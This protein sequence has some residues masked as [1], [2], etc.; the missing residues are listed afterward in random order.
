LVDRKQYFNK[1]SPEFKIIF[2]VNMGEFDRINQD[3][4]KVKVSFEIPILK[5]FLRYYRQA[6]LDLRYHEKSDEALLISQFKLQITDAIQKAREKLII[7]PWK[8]D[9]EAIIVNEIGQQ[10]VLKSLDSL[11]LSSTGSQKI[12]IE[13][14]Y[15]PFALKYINHQFSMLKSAPGK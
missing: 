13:I 6:M 5:S 8:G 11:N 3:V 15:A 2:D 7:P 9:L 10:L 4:G 1:Y 14:N 12:I